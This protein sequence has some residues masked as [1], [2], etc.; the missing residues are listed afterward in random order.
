MGAEK[1]EGR[2]R[3]GVVGR[4]D[5]CRGFGE[6]GVDTG[7]GRKRE[8]RTV[9]EQQHF[10]LADCKKVKV[11]MISTAVG[12]RIVPFFLFLIFSIFFSIFFHFLFSDIFIF[13]TP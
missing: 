2:K 12:Q 10:G 6:E 1:A 3:S 9:M 7:R 13:V 4:E 8:I 5:E 11:A